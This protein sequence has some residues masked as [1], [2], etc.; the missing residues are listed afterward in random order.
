VRILD[1]TG[2]TVGLAAVRP[3]DDAL[4]D[5]VRLVARHGE[6]V[7]AAIQSMNGARFVLDT[8]ER[9]GW[10]VALADAQRVKGLAPLI[11]KTDRIDAWVLADLARRDL[12][13]AIWLPDLATREER[14]RAR[15]RLHLVRHRTALED[16]IHATLIAFGHPLPVPDLFGTK[17]REPLERLDVPEP[18]PR[19]SP[20]TCASSTTSDAR[21]PPARPSCAAS[22]PTTP[23]S[24]C[25]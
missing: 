1:D 9:H 17:G 21:S 13:P 22:A 23:T 24:P 5:P 8:L 12:V 4:R 3:D 25:S 7:E 15:C 2:R 18:W 6:P 14:E 20:R 19:P 16:R 10:D 11:A